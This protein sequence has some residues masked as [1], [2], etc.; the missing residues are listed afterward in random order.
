MCETECALHETR[1]TGEPIIGKSGYIIGADGSR[2]PI[3]V[4]T[5]VFK[6]Q[7]ATWLAVQKPFAI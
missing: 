5:A 3:S 4:S 6:D 2:L 1:Q 7:A